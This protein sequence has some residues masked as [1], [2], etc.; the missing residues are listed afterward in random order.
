MPLGIK[1]APNIFQQTIDT[2]L[3]GLSG[4]AAYIDDILSSGKTLP[5][6]NENSKPYNRFWVSC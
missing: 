1:I 6:F 4:T 3:S 2:M 5:K